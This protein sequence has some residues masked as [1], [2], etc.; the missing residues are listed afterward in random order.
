M[1]RSHPHKYLWEH[2]QNTWKIGEKILSI[3]KL[4]FSIITIERLNML[5]KYILLLHDIGKSTQY[6]QEYITDIEN[7]IKRIRHESSPL[8][9]HG[10]LSAAIACG[11]CCDLGFNEAECFILFICILRH[12]EDFE[13]V[14]QYFGNKIYEHLNSDILRKQFES[15]HKCDIQEV[16]NKCDIQYDFSKLDFE[17]LKRNIENII[18]RQSRK[19][20]KEHFFCMQGNLLINLIFSLLTYSD[21]TEAIFHNSNYNIND[22]IK[23]IT[24][25]SELPIEN[26][27][28]YLNN[29]IKQKCESISVIRDE[30]CENVFLSIKN[31]EIENKKILSINLPTGTGKTLTAIKS[32]FLLRQRLK[33]E[34]NISSRIIYLLP[35]TSI[36]EQNYDVLVKILKEADSSIILKH[37]CFSERKYTVKEENL[38]EQ[39]S[40]HLIESWDSQ[41]VVSTFVQ[42]M[43]S[44]F[45]NKNRQ[46]KK[47]H[48]IAN[49]IVILDE[50]QAIPLKY[51][52]LINKV[53]NCMANYLECR[54]ILM[55]ATMPLI[56]SENKGEIFELATKKDYFFKKLDR[57][58][59]DFSRIKNPISL[60]QFKE[61]MIEEKE[62]YKDESI[63]IIVN[64]IKSSIKVYNIIKELF[65]EEKDTEL[66]YLS[67]NIIPKQRIERIN[68]IK[69]SISRKIIVSTQVVEAGVDIDV[70]RVYRDFAPVDSINQAAGRCNRNN[71]LDQKGKVIIFQLKDNKYSYCQY[72]YDSCLLEATRNTVKDLDIISE[73]KIFDLS[74]QYFVNLVKLSSQDKG[75]KILEYIEELSYEKAFD[76]TKNPEAFSLIEQKYNYVDVFIEIDDDA[77]LLWSKYCE[78]KSIKD[79]FERKRAFEKIKSDFYSYIISIP[80]SALYKYMKP[81]DEWITYISNDMTGTL[82]DIHTGFK[83]TEEL[84]DYFI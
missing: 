68:D 53:I 11:I 3:K 34:L 44:I 39:I 23:N 6:F 48:N 18:S 27:E 71:F 13:D 47:Y 20:I 33:E 30:A 77:K 14:S 1:L 28:K 43:H 81:G 9:N 4:N 41:I 60:E 67:T 70:Q 74:Q 59:I 50:V 58:D 38:E 29:D 84:G 79:K 45:S 31:L 17:M 19:T 69:N 16:L 22:F 36:I 61:I 83:R 15:I 5:C 49:S 66:F 46:L 51:W 54:F 2:L 56:F 82:Y 55:T 72:V 62:K 63:L 75:K 37:H 8:K 26:I 73:Q 21:K 64:T 25:F 7:E 57:I 65:N 12:H 24:K 78:F 40:E 80:Y 35:F 42:F 32:A 52:E 10:F 76:T